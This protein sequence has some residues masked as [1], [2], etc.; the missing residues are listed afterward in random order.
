MVLRDNDGA[1]C[2]AV[3]QG[4]LDICRDAGREDTLVRVVCEELEAWYLGEPE[5]LAEAFEDDRLRGIRRRPRFR[6]PDGVRQPS[7]TL[8]QL[9]PEFQK[10]SGA[11]RMARHL[12]LERNRSTS[13][14][15]FMSGIDAVLAE[16]TD[17]EHR[18]RQGRRD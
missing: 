13:F 18:S 5:A 15:A 17:S 1:D 12:S 11:R 3:K 16:M 7:K 8:E 14:H 10:V 6:N 9:V 2:V 4:L